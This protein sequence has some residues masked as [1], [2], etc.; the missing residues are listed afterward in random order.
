[1]AHDVPAAA[2]RFRAL[3]LAGPAIRL[4][5]PMPTSS[6]FDVAVRDRTG[7]SQD[8]TGRARLPAS[9]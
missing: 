1:L 3:A 5:D 4:T 9:R 7:Y 6:A 2:T 8:L